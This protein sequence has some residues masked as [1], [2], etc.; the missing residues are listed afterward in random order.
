MKIKK[1]II[2]NIDKI[3]IY[4]IF[5]DHLKEEY[6]NKNNYNVHKIMSEFFLQ[7][8]NNEDIEKV[9]TKFIKDVKEKQIRLLYNINLN[10]KIEIKKIKYNTLENNSIVNIYF[11][12]KYN[13]NELSIHKEIPKI[14][15]E[16]INKKRKEKYL[17]FFYIMIGFDTGQ[18]WGLHPLFYNYIKTNYKRP[19]ECFASPFN[20]N[21]EDY[22]S[23]LYPID[24]YYGSKDDFFK[25]FLKV[26][27][28]VYIINPPFIESIIIKV[29]YFIEQ[30]LLN[31][32][33][34][35][36]FLIPQWDDLILPWYNKIKKIYNL[37]M[38]N[39]N[40]HNLILYDY[41]NNKPLKCNSG[42]YM[43]YINNTFYEICNKIKSD[44]KK[45]HF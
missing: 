45:Y 16:K 28:D 13:D 33:V 20:N 35:I 36:F 38:F 27:Y 4:I 19:I 31:E 40:K 30:K 10:K 17:L 25:K 5:L 11:N 12:I 3:N 15:Y 22:F 43:I 24:K 29:L 32:K 37:K 1:F 7:I 41:I 44:I 9:K 23:L 21:L 6:N 18:F 26:K 34:E 2:K 8:L 39:F 14:I 42:T